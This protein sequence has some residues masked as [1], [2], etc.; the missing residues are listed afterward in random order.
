MLKTEPWTILQEIFINWRVA[1]AQNYTY[2][3]SSVF[4]DYIPW[5]AYVILFYSYCVPT[6]SVRNGRR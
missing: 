3:I 2:W 1:W 5:K 6:A 4:M